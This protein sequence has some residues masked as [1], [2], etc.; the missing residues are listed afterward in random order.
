MIPIGPRARPDGWREVLTGRPGPLIAVA[1][2]G[3]AVGWW[4]GS[5]AAVIGVPLAVAMARHWATVTFRKTER[6]RATALTLQLVDALIQQLKGGRSLS[7]SV[8]TAIELRLVGPGALF[9]TTLPA[10]TRLRAGLDAGAGLEVALGR[11]AGWLPGRPTRGSGDDGLRL[12]FATL[13]VL[14]QRGGPALPALE[15]LD[16][17]L[18]SA[19]WLE[20]EARVQAAQATT[21]AI[22]LAALPVVFAGGLAV[23]EPDLARFYCFEPFGAACLVVSGLLSYLSWWWMH[24]IIWRGP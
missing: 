15:R 7:Q 10:L 9:P 2:V 16:D 1:V 8:R 14:V 17:T 13:A 20:Q 12:T 21:S 3:M 18:R 22:T 11:A 24:R 19:H 6:A 23:L 4:A 5:P